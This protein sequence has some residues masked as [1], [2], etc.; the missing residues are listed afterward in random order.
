L[1][2]TASAIAVSVVRGGRQRR[3]HKAFPRYHDSRGS[4][5]LEFLAPRGTGFH[6]TQPLTVRRVQANDAARERAGAGKTCTDGEFVRADGFTC[7][8]PRKGATA[9]GAIQGATHESP[10]TA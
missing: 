1:N 3:L 5:D 8:Q 7:A 4:L 10:I 2:R 9:Q 6:Q